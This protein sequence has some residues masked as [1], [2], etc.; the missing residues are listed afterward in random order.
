MNRAKGFV[1][2]TGPEGTVEFETFTCGHCSTI[3]Q[4]PHK[5]SPDALGG[6]CKQCMTMICPGCVE[7]MTCD[8]FEKKL[9]RQE[10]RSRFFRQIGV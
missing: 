4:V 6:L 5:A 3:V 8:P 1:Q 10:D 7:K 2:I 9:K